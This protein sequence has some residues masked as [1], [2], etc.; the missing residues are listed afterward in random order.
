MQVLQCF[1]R[2]E[3]PELT[4]WL[5]A[6]SSWQLHDSF[7][8]A[9]FCFLIGWGFLLGWLHFLLTGWSFVLCLVECYPG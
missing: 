6:V 3:M 1:H 5:V 7:W 4:R 8:L 2:L 9:L